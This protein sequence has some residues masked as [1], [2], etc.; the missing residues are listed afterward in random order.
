MLPFHISL[1]ARSP[2]VAPGPSRDLRQGA[3]RTL[4][5]PHE[6][7]ATPFGVSFEQAASA[8]EQIERLFF[9][10]DGSFVWTSAQIQNGTIAPSLEAGTWQLEGNLFDRAGRLLFVDLKG[11]CPNSEFDRLLSAFGWPDTPIMVQLA[12]DALFLDEQEFRRYCWPP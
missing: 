5:V 8:L 1:H 4:A 10:P 6:A 11:A 7:L 3:F 2:L 9:E 12:C